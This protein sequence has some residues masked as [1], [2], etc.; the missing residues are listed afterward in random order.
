MG[1]GMGDRMFAREL[2]GMEVATASGRRVG[3]LEDIVIET[4]GGSLRYLL[5]SAS[6]SVFDAPRKV[7]EKGRMVVETDRM[8]IEDGRIIIN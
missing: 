4:V 6:G 7:D 8:R 2:I 5:V 1:D 3:I